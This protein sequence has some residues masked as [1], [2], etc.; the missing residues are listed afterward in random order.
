MHRITSET[1]YSIRYSSEPQFSPDGQFVIYVHTAI[2][3][4]ENKAHS[5]LRRLHLATSTDEPLTQGRGDKGLAQDKNPSFSPNGKQLAFVSNR[6]GK[7]QLFVLSLTGG[8]PTQVTFFAKGIQSYTWLRDGQG[9]VVAARQDD[10]QDKSDV[11]VI[12][13]LRYWGN[14]EG[15]YGDE[16]IRLWAVRVD[17]SGLEP[18]TDGD[19]NANDPALSPDG[20]RVVFA[21]HR[22]FDQR[23]VMPSLYTIDLETR[24][25]NR[26]YEGKGAAATP[27]FSPDG[28]W[29]AFF[30]DEQG[31]NGGVHPHVWLVPSGGGEARDLTASFLL[32]V[33]NHVGT[34]TRYETATSRPVWSEDSGKIYFLSTSGGDC[35]LYSVTLDGLVSKENVGE[36]FVINSFALYDQKWV[37]AKERPTRPAELYLQQAGELIPL[38]EHNEQLFASLQVAEPER[39]EVRADDGLRIE[40]WLLKPAGFSSDNVYPLVL[41]I[42]GGP[43]TAYGNTFHLEF[44]ILA[45]MGYIV[46]YTN[47]RGSHGYGEEFVRACIGDWGGQDFEDLM[48]AVDYAAGLPYVDGSN[49]FVTGGSYGGYMTNWIVTQTDRFQ[50]AVTQRSISNLYSMFG[51]SDIGF[52]FNKRELGGVDL[53]TDEEFIMARSPIRY[54][55]KVKTPTKIIHSEQDIRCPMEQAEQWFIALK[56]LGVDTQFVRFPDEN[57]ELSRSGKPKHRQ[58]RLEHIVGWFENYRKQK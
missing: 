21:A 25:L 15:F 38:T 53:W 18:L 47:P 36:N 7:P 3:K 23:V 51:T 1:L 52:W 48:A 31:E 26:V 29:I 8:E 42:H 28:Q 54:A 22:D 34:D 57:H 49:L 10:P 14:G 17:G 30:G 40:G 4:Q 24:E 41:E 32:A 45:A 11:Q 44:Q 5:Q 46:L 9:F 58:E 37:L 35:Y 16:A 27:V 55:D 12:S 33:G 2:S 20:T 43:H 50:A 19:F 6:S 13:Q 56:R 39:M